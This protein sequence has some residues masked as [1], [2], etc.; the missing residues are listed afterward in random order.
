MLHRSYHAVLNSTDISNHTHETPGASIE[1]PNEEGH[2]ESFETGM[3]VR[4]V[5][6]IPADL[7]P[8]DGKATARFEEAMRSR[9]RRV[10]TGKRL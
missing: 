7:A 8:G 10:F 4:T 1:M 3:A 2:S 9:C 6:F 5:E